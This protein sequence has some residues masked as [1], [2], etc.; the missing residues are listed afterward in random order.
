M[1]TLFF[2][3]H[4]RVMFSY[5]AVANADNPIFAAMFSIFYSEEGLNDDYPY[6]LRFERQGFE[7]RSLFANSGDVLMILILTIILFPF[8]LLM[9]HLF[10]R[11]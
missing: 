7:S 4:A 2:P 6:T 8:A 11:N 3:A 1:M 9:N 10:N 5:V